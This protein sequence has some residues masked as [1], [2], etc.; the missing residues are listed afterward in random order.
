MLVRG[1][2]SA[3]PGS[4]GAR[5]VNPATYVARRSAAPD[6]RP[7]P[8]PPGKL[9]HLLSA[10]ALLVASLIGTPAAAEAT[11]GPEIAQRIDSPASRADFSL[12]VAWVRTLTG[13][14]D[15]LEGVVTRQPAAGTFSVDVRLAAL[16]LYMSNPEHAAWA[17]SEEFFDAQRHPWI[18]F[19]AEAVPD[20][21]LRDGGLLS[22]T[23]SLRGHSGPVD[24]EVEPAECPLPGLECEVVAHGE[25]KRSAFGMLARRVVVSD[26]VRLN[27]SIKVHQAP[28]AP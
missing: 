10:L 7:H 18:R 26:K 1:A 23:L 20:A 13:R 12:R 15:Y 22:G 6:P 16:S 19:N 25:L 5:P 21:V 8:R 17:Q 24:F 3:A 27:L 9:P 11:S 4:V 14:F 2:P 28:I